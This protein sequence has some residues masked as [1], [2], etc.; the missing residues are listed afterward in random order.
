MMNFEPSTLIASAYDAALDDPKWSEWVTGIMSATGGNGLLACI[1]DSNDNSLLRPIA[2]EANPKAFDD[3]LGGMYLHD[4]QVGIVSSFS[5][6]TIY[7]NIPGERALDKKGQDYLKWQRTVADFAHNLTLT[8]P[9]PQSDFKFA[10]CVHRSRSQ[11]AIGNEP[12]RVLRAILPELTRAVTLGF[13]HAEMLQDVF[14]NGMQ[15]GRRGQSVALVDERGCVVR[16]SESAATLV[17]RADGV[18]IKSG[19]L[20][21]SMHSDDTRLSAIVARATVKEGALSGA[22][23]IR[24]PSGRPPLYLNCYPLP[25]SSRMLAPAE[26]AALIVV[27]DPAA[28]QHAQ[29][30]LYKQAFGMTQR[31]AELASAMMEGHS[32]ESAAATMNIGIATARTHIRRIF[33]KTGTIGQTSLV[34]LLSTIF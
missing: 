19:R 6:P 11:G 8:V 22:T 28:A 33:E 9:I 14:W 3:Y 12:E 16:L 17:S 34:L 15:E 2:F 20:R 29:P 21:A 10:F 1:I 25:R 30:H 13:K 27:T 18:D 31:E 4:P 23:S 7:R 24:R 32:V 26:A 5:R